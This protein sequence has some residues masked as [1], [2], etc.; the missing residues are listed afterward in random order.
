[1]D[2]YRLALPSASYRTPLMR[3]LT[4]TL[5]SRSPGHPGRM[6]P[7]ASMGPADASAAQLLGTFDPLRFGKRNRGEEQIDRARRTGRRPK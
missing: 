3:Q 5:P 1:M 4:V 2:G 6:S 7:P